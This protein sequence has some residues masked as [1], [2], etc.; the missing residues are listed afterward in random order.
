MY[1]ANYDV[2]QINGSQ[3]IIIVL[4]W[5]G[6]ILGPVGDGSQSRVWKI[7]SCLPFFSGM[8]CCKGYQLSIPGNIQAKERYFSFRDIGKEILD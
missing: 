5:S 6:G 4:H 1:R 2:K 7:I 3:G 8:G